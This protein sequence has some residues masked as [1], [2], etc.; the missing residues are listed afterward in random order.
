M[1]NLRTFLLC[2]LCCIAREM[3]A[4]IND[5]FSDGDLRNNPR[6]QGDLNNF[7]H[8]TDGQLQLNAPGTDTSTILVQ[9]TI[10]DNSEWSLDI[11]LD[12]PPSNQNRLRVYVLADRADIWTAN[13]YYVEIGETGSADAIR[14]FRQNGAVRTSIATGTTGLVAAAPVV[15]TLVMRRTAPGIW[16][17]TALSG[18]QTLPQFEVTDTTYKGGCHQFFGIQ[19]INTTT[20]KD[21]FLFDNLRITTTQPDLVPPGTVRATANT[22][23]EVVVYFDKPV[24]SLSAILPAAYTIDKGVGVPQKATLLPDKR[25]VLLSLAKPLANGNFRLETK[26]IRD[27]YGNVSGSQ[28]VDFEYFKL[29]TAS[30]YDII[31][32]EIYPDVSPTKG[33]PEIEW[34]ELYNRSTKFIRLDDLYFSDASGAPKRLPA[35]V[36]A[37]DSFVVLCNPAQVT[38]LRKVTSRALGVAGFPSLNDAGDVISLTD[39]TGQYIDRVPFLSGWHTDQSKDDGGWS[40]ERIDPDKPCLG[41]I[42]WQSCPVLPGGTPGA[43]NAALKRSPDNDR[44]Y[45]FSVFPIDGSTLRLTFSEG[46]ERNSATS[47]DAYF[48]TPALATQQAAV[49]IEQPNVVVLTLAQSMTGSTIYRI[50]VGDKLLDCSGNAA[51]RDTLAF[52]LP[53]VPV[54]GDI[55]INEILFNPPTGGARY[56]E[57]YN[58]SSKIFSWTNFFLANFYEDNDVENIGRERLLLPGDYAVFTSDRDEVIG[59]H[60]GI[61]PEKIIEMP[62]PTLDDKNGNVTLY[63][64]KDGRKVVSDSVVYA[65][66]WHNA[67]FNVSQRD[68]VALERISTEEPSNSP[69]NWTSA[70]AN[71]TGV[72]GTPTLPN[73]QSRLTQNNSA[74][75]LLDLPV[76]RL[77]PD[78][79]GFEDFLDI[80]YQLPAP[81]FAATLTI[82]DSGGIP[83]RR[84]ARQE[85][86]G[87]E[88]FLRWDGEMNTGA[89]ARPGIYVLFAEFFDGTGT[90]R[91]SK[92]A[93]SVVYR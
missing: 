12:F 58:R 33:L 43:A 92:K 86:A 39:G 61:Y 41:A 17:L 9:G 66:S 83:V 74:D 56:V 20:N 6:W 45:L 30:E 16:T 19:C 14:L 89:R 82:F 68:G 67:L 69:A 36:L 1:L 11:R 78:G 15:F 85:L 42:N 34:V 21:K 70:S 32:N 88:G 7:L 62:L 53:E 28:F 2:L 31:V 72:P 23:T 5:D 22:D 47:T 10:Q 65:D 93:F 81:G 37:P 24:D 26:G 55:V 49:T 4:Q 84:I 35:V 52:G 51:R 91:Q 29:E 13:G 54:P 90:V 63:W 79:D 76:A 57:V 73:S 60:V 48:I 77:S 46:L 27:C 8:T 3:T 25:S 18:G 80:Y 75:H 40:L 50:A 87:T 71:K 38:E 59:R 64:A 44:P